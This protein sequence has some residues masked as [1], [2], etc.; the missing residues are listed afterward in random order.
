MD[1]FIEDLDQDE[2]FG[3]TFPLM[4][5]GMLMLLLQRPQTRMQQNINHS[6][7]GDL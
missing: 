7:D 6:L 2:L 1:S 5:M 4:A 3:Q